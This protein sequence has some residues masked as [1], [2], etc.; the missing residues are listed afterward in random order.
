MGLTGE[1]SFALFSNHSR[2]KQKFKLLIRTSQGRQNGVLLLASNIWRFLLLAKATQS[3]AEAL[4]LPQAWQKRGQGRCSSC[5]HRGP[6]TPRTRTRLG[7]PKHL[8]SGLKWAAG[9]G[10][11][12]YGLHG[13]TKWVN[14]V[15]GASKYLDAPSG[16]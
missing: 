3:V 13:N 5:R 6:G 2:M 15:N 16:T 7:C 1:A 10:G 11:L 12:V 14:S 8:Q 4:P 9:L